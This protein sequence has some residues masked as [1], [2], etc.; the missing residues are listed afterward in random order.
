M[1][2]H[3]RTTLLPNYNTKSLVLP[4]LINPLS[5]N[6]LQVLLGRTFLGASKVGDFENPAQQIGEADAVYFALPKLSAQPKGKLSKSLKLINGWFLIVDCSL[7][8]LD[9]WLATS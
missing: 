1:R 3:Y 8:I 4:P 5:L 7:L 6:L 9:A 2:Q